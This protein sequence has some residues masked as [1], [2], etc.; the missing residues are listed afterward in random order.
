MPRLL[1]ILCL[2][3]PLCAQEFT[4]NFS[5]TLEVGSVSNSAREGGGNE[6]SIGDFY[7]NPVLKLSYPVDGE[8]I[9]GIQAVI[10]YGT[11]P[12]R[13]SCATYG[14]YSPTICTCGRGHFRP[15]VYSPSTGPSITYLHRR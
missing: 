7:L 2:S 1:L 8:V 13:I 9:T 12:D 6:T 14:S 10:D 5:G 4:Y 3:G 15:P 11:P